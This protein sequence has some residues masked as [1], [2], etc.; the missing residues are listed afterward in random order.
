M[1]SQ[2]VNQITSNIEFQQQSQEISIEVGFKEA[3]GYQRTMRFESDAMCQKMVNFQKRMNDF[4]ERLD[5]FQN[6]I[7]ILVD[8]ELEQEERDGEVIRRI[9]GQLDGIL[10]RMRLLDCFVEKISIIL[11][12]MNPDIDAL[13]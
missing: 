1:D 7:G 8:Q 10:E 3:A 4:N 12:V 9:E 13:D 2:G 6:T 5:E 11:Q